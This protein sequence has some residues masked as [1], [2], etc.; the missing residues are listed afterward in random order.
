MR[1]L[2][3][4]GSGFIGSNLIFQWIKQY[5]G[6]QILNLDKLTYAASLNNDKIFAQYPNYRFV[7]ADLVDRQKIGRIIRQFRPDA[8]IH[9][10]AETH[11]DNSI[12]GPDVF[13]WTNVVGTFNLLEECRQL[14]SADKQNFANCRFLHISTDEVY[15]TLG[16]E[17]YFA[18]T[19]A[20]S[21]NSPYA[22]SKAGSDH[23]VRAY[24]NTYGM[25]TVITN[26]SNNFGPY[27][28][29]EK[30]IPTV[31]CAALA[32][33]PIPVYGQGE[34]VRD[35]LFVTD[36]CRALDVIFHH[37]R[38]GES[39]N[40]GGR[41]EWKNID[42]IHKICDLLNDLVGQ[43]PAGDYNKLITFVA[44]RPGHDLRYA[45]DPTKLETEMGWQVS[46]DFNSNLT[47][48]IRWYMGERRFAMGNIDSIG[49]I[50]TTT[51]QQ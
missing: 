44:D 33:R 10:A 49:G 31:I 24:H 43:G 3:T 40:I 35:W 21:P 18:E 12:A 1:L 8:V 34:N 45:I 6:D 7:Q 5:S 30:L 39:Y 27:Q 16:Y 28:H 14:W 2:I 4:G 13:V 26:C 47:T 17:G 41:N 38:C 36:H 11:V 15:G 9:L 19:T 46:G 29:P 23:L 32:H 25:N 51:G 42:L 48:T 37:G 20:Y 22:A 50:G